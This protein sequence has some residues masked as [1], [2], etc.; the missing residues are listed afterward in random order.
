MGS[1]FWSIFMDGRYFMY[2]GDIRCISF[3][4]MF[5]KYMLIIVVF[6]VFGIFF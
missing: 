6:V 3:Y 4:L 1:F 5:N 2:D